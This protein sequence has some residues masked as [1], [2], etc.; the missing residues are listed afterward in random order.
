MRKWQIAILGLVDLI[1]RSELPQGFPSCIR[2]LGLVSSRGSGWIT[3]LSR[4]RVI[5]RI[6]NSIQFLSLTP[7]MSLRIK[8]HLPDLQLI[9]VLIDK[10]G[11]I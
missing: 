11:R 9:H 7:S 1:I 4:P 8:E 5:P 2:H 3:P 10:S 6:Y